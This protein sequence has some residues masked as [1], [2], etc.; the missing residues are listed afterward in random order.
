[1]KYL[2]V[3]SPEKLSPMHGD[4]QN[5]DYQREFVLRFLENVVLD[6]KI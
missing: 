6:S 3:S 2:D 4:L 5:T 1:M